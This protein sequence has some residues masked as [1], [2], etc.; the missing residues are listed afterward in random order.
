MV[1][2]MFKIHWELTEA[3]SLSEK[4]PLLIIPKEIDN[5]QHN[6]YIMQGL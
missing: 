4:F 3:D 5:I 2:D 6:I 1:L